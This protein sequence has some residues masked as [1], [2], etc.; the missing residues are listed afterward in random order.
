MPADGHFAYFVQWAQCKLFP[1]H[2]DTAVNDMQVSD[3]KYASPALQ[4]FPKKFGILE[5]CDNNTVFIPSVSAVHSLVRFH[6][7]I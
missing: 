3:T 4:W 6:S 2:I 5:T 1:F 7:V